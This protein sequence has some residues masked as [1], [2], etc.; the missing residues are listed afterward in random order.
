LFPLLFNLVRFCAF[1]GKGSKK[2]PQ[3]MDIFL[4]KVHVASTFQKKSTNISMP[5]FL[6]LF[7]F[8]AFSGGSLPKVFR[9]K[10]VSKSFSKKSTKNPKPIFYQLFLGTYLVGEFKNTA[11]KTPPKALALALFWLLTHPP[12][13]GASVFFLLPAPCAVPCIYIYRHRAPGCG[14]F[15]RCGAGFLNTFEIPPPPPAAMRASA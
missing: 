3:T 1:P 7:C 2:T 10:A 4:Q 11:Q 5:V 9:K 14:V 15:G 6:R 12:T 8:F 13:T